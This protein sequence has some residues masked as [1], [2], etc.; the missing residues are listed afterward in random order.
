MKHE[1]LILCNSCSIWQSSNEAVSEKSS[2]AADSGA[3]RPKS[4]EL[5]GSEATEAAALRQ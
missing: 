3:G 2:E 5:Q 1:M 4:S